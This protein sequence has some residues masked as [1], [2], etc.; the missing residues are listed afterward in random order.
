MTELPPPLV[1]AIAE[2]RQRP[3]DL[4]AKFGLGAALI[5]FGLIEPAMQMRAQLAG[6]IAEAIANGVAPDMIIEMLL[7]YYSSFAKRIETERNLRDCFQLLLEPVSALGR[8]LQEAGLPLALHRPGAERPWRAAF[9]LHTPTMLGHVDALLEVLRHRPRGLPWA[10]DPVVFLLDGAAAGDPDKTAPLAAAVA[11]A[12]GRLVDLQ[13]E[14]ATGISERLARL[15]WMRRHIAEAG[16]THL[17]WVSVPVLSDLAF[18][19]KLAPVQVL[20]T[21]KFHPYHLPEVDGYISYGSWFED[22]RIEHGESW[23][24]VPQIFSRPSMPVDPARVAEERRRFSQHDLLFGTL[25]RSEKFNSPAFLNAVVRILRDNPQAGYL[26]TGR[27]RHEGVAAHF[28]AA[29]VADRCHFIG[30]VDTALY[31]RVL[32]IFLETFPFGCGLTGIQAM[33][34]GTPLLSYAVPETIHGMFFQRPLAAGGAG[35]AQIRHLLAPDDGSA[36]LLYPD[37]VDGYVALANRLARDSVFRHAVG[38][39][40]QAYFRSQLTDA[41]RMS[42]RFFAILAGCKQPEAT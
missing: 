16:I 37:T 6:V 41:V 10:D 21:L 1:Q 22:K 27:E 20:W 3:H 30:W 32:D 38:K 34:A 9:L 18:C 26:W 17:V 25:A 11:E 23:E 33:E 8:R 42:A 19:M 24:V 40:G 14:T 29:G 39:A 4:G 31:A 15:Q 28:A 36:P 7:V 5:D 35:A 2:A 12:G 13:A